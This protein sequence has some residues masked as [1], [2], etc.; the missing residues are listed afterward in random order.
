MLTFYISS[1]ILF[2]VVACI[3]IYHDKGVSGGDLLFMSI[4]GV[5]PPVNIFMT[6]VFLGI[7]L[8]DSKFL[9]NFKNK[10]FF[11]RK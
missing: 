8:D 3:A 2:F 5:L 11:N 7:M 1:V 4:I 6:F 10:Q 9:K